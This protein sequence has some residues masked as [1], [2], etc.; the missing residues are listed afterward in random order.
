VLEVVACPSL[1]APEFVT[2]LIEV[3]VG[4]IH[5]GAPPGVSASTML[6]ETRPAASLA[7]ALFPAG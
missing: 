3:A 1:L 6:R 4:K 2:A 5:G 7:G